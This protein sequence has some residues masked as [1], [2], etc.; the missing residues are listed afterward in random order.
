MSG[1]R[2][3]Y[4]QEVLDLAQSAANVRRERDNLRVE[5]QSLKTDLAVV[6]AQLDERDA[7]INRLESQLLIATMRNGQQVSIIEQINRLTETYH[8]SIHASHNV[9]LLTN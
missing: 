2:I 5:V 8:E 9:A 7:Q 1:P 4:D 3:E 6:A